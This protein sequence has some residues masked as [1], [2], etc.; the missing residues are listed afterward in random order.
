M[1][2]EKYPDIESVLKV[3][4]SRDELD[5]PLSP[6]RLHKGSYLDPELHSAGILYCGTWAKAVELAGFDYSELLVKAR[7]RYPTAHTV[8][9]EIQD[10]CHNDISIY[11]ADVYS[12][13]GPHRDIA[14]YNSARKHFGSWEAAVKAAGMVY[15][16]GRKGAVRRYCDKESVVDE[17]L[18]RYSDNLPL[19]SAQV[20]RGENKDP[21]LYLSGRE[22]FGKWETALEVAGIDYDEVRFRKPRRYP[23]KTS[24]IE[25]IRSRKTSGKPLTPVAILE[26]QDREKTLYRSAR[27][28]F[29]SW[30]KA[31]KASGVEYKD[32][33]RGL[34]PRY[35]NQDAVLNEIRRRRESGVGISYSA[36]QVKEDR[37]TALH[38][39]AIRYFGSWR[40]A[41][42]KAGLDYEPIVYKSRTSRRKYPDERSVCEAIHKRIGGGMS[43]SSTDVTKGVKPN[44]ALFKSGIRFYGSWRAAVEAAGFQYE[45][46]K[47]PRPRKYPDRK[48][49]AKEIRRRHKAGLPILGKE[50]S[51]GKHPNVQLYNCGRE[52]FDSWPDAIV[53]AGISY[54]EIRYKKPFRYPDKGSVVEEIRRRHSVGIPVNS[55]AVEVGIYCDYKLLRSARTY[56]GSWSYALESADVLLV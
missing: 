54:D 7:F 19:S 14:L 23:D 12:R 20:L 3:I 31:V 24:V 10:R 6:G 9:Q 47:K 28:F 29:G 27:E 30:K 32:A 17:I 50:L 21:T 52:Y 36:V 13:P 45:V 25:E 38:S 46:L 15:K 53:A 40:K 16:P 37:D 41:V 1:G 11:L 8:I 2:G 33:R 4:C 51:R 39:T 18:R 48:A 55:Q 34:I 44:H 43:V 49:V 26:G 42:S 5:L 35:P 22:Y 56:F